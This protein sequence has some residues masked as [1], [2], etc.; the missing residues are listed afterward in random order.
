MTGNMGNKRIS[1][2]ELLRM[3][4]KRSLAPGNGGT[5]F[6]VPPD[7][8]TEPARIV[9]SRVLLVISDP[10]MDPVTGV[11]LSQKLGWN[12][13][14]NLVNEFISTIHTLSAGLARYQIVQRVELTDFL[15]LADGFCYV[16]A[17]YMDV[18]NRVT[19]AHKPE[20]VN[21][22][23]LLDKLDILARVTRYDIDEVWVFN[24]PYG[25]FYE[26]VMAGKN[27]FWCNAKPLANTTGC[28]RKFIIMGLSYE[29]GL[30][31]MLE[32][33]GHRAESLLAQVFKCQDF[34][35]WAYQH[36]RVPATT[37]AGLNLFQQYLCFDQIA[38]RQAGIGTFH[39]AP[40]STCDYEFDNPN[41]VISNCYDWLNFP[42]F[43]NDT[44]LISSDEW[45]S[46]L[47]GHH[48]WWFRHLPRG[49]GRINGIV[50]NWWQYIMD[51]NLV[52]M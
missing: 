19:T 4:F 35:T 7:N 3:L 45:G 29:R 42:N 26:S 8:T 44:R 52:I 6:S 38:P 21:Y 30:G 40:N 9:T 16:P 51:P 10:V 31:E 41:Q 14:D 13:V 27:A 5:G 17:T 28:K 36:D 1:F 34:L 11:Q 48:E 43:Q 22:Q 24:F 15:P 25:G 32:S 2:L 23:A 46:N 50:N 12:R 39:Y 49:A 18:H 20:T 33:F 37:D 47:R